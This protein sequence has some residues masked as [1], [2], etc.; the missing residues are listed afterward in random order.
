MA[1]QIEVSTC[2]NPAWHG[3]PRTQAEAIQRIIE[4]AEAGKPGHLTTGIC[5]LVGINFDQ[6]L[7]FA[8]ADE[9]V[10]LK[11]VRGLAEHFILKQ[12]TEDL[13]HCSQ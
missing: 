8:Q 12:K 1:R 5:E 6:F 10:Q 13:G 3:I 11:V 7:Q 2:E 4:M 9:N